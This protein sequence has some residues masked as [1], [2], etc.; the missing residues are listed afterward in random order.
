[1]MKAKSYYYKYQ[2]ESEL[3]LKLM[4]LVKSTEDIYNIYIN[5]IRKFHDTIR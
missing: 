5:E 3:K 1:M 4:K 2:Y